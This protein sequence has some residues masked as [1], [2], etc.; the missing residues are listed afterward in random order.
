M[1]LRCGF[2]KSDI[3]PPPDGGGMDLRILSFWYDRAGR[4]GEVRDP[5]YARAAFFESAGEAA[6]IVALDL[7]GDAV[8]LTARI[9]ERVNDILAMPAERVMVLCTHAHATPETIGLTGHPVH[10]AWL[11]TLVT[12][13]AEAVRQAAADAEPC[14]VRLGEDALHGVVHNRAAQ[15]ES[16]R[17][18]RLGPTERERYGILDEALRVAAFLRDDGSE[19]GVLFNFACHP[20]CVQAR[21]FISADW[22]GAA[23]ALLERDRPAMFLNGACGDADPVRMKGTE[24]LEWTGRAVADKVAEILSDP[25]AMADADGCAVRSA[26]KVVRLP[27]REIADVEGLEREARELETKA[28]AAPPG[29]DGADNALHERLFDIREQLA[30]ARMPGT[31]PAE[32]HLLAVGPLLVAGVPVE[33]AA[34]LGDDIRHAAARPSWVVG[35]A[36]GYIGYCVPRASY[37]VGGYETTPARW[38]PL[39]PGAA[40]ILRDEAVAL[41]GQFAQRETRG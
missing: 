5:L 27:R 21:D 31:L 13:A 23:L 11:D 22:P 16:D 1:E 9:R 36:N 34:C 24:A 38:S 40:E 28:A 10:E 18:Q 39:A 7:I 6:C 32:I 37:E 12:G 26:R 15:W 3:S 25:D 20:V 4:Y 2:G 19:A 14:R 41:V 35:Y 17:M 30:V 8:G 33:L 29:P